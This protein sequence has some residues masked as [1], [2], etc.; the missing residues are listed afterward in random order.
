MKAEL[1][2]HML[3]P[4]ILHLNGRNLSLI[5]LQQESIAK[6]QEHKRRQRALSP[7]TRCRGPARFGV[8]SRGD[9]LVF[10]AG[11]VEETCFDLWN[12]IKLGFGSFQ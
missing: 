9:G 1:R 11:Q 4:S 10:W 2:E 12:S 3:P 5:S 8:G 7:G 6:R